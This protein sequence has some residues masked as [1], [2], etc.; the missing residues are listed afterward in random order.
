[1]TLDAN[2]R[3]QQRAQIAK[4]MSD[5]LPAI[6]L[7]TTPN[8]HAVAARIK[9]VSPTT[10]PGTMGRITWNIQSWELD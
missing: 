3:V 8:P 7:L 6:Q 5:E 9:N 4:I 10:R 1:V 2:E